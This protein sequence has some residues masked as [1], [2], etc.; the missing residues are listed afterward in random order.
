VVPS[1]ADH[2]EALALVPLGTREFAGCWVDV[3]LPVLAP[4]KDAVSGVRVCFCDPIPV[5]AVASGR[6]LRVQL[7]QEAAVRLIE[8]GTAGEAV[9][10]GPTGGQTSGDRRGI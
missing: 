2:G 1:H 9:A 8:A 7:S 4:L 10:V 3:G 5:V 6:L